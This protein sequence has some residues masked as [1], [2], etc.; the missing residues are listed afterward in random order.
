VGAANVLR[1]T[2]CPI[3]RNGNDSAL[4]P[5]KTTS[6]LQ[7]QAADFVERGKRLNLRTDSKRQAAVIIL[8]I[9]QNNFINCLRSDEAGSGFRTTLRH[10]A[11]K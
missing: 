8:M 7:N 4:A 6:R 10:Y 3:S 5:G 11:D 1:D 9:A 2:S